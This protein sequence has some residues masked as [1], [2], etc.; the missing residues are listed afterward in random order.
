MHEIPEM[1]V[2][3]VWKIPQRR[4]WQPTPVFLP[5]KSH[6]QDKP[7][8]LQFMVLQSQTWLRD[9]IYVHG[10]FPRGKMFG[11]PVTYLLAYKTSVINSG[12]GEQ[13]CQLLQWK[14]IIPFLIFMFKSINW[15]K[16]KMSLNGDPIML[17]SKKSSNKEI[18]GMLKI[19][20]F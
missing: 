9:W 13:W 16:N 10:C 6:G 20:T 1:Q 18:L 8:G 12:W 2:W 14:I 4:K 3:G 15:S 19:G 5:E 17:L 7:G 11:Q